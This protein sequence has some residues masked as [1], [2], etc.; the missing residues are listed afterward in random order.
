MVEKARAPTR[1][2]AAAQHD[3]GDNMLRSLC[4]VAIAM[5][6]LGLG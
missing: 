3:P 5:T 2:G 4:D 6:W 1:A